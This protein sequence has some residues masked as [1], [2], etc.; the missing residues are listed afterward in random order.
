MKHAAVGGLAQSAARYACR[1]KRLNEHGH[2]G[3]ARVEIALSHGAPRVRRPQ[4][5]PT[6]PQCNQKFVLIA[7]TE[8]ALE[9]TGESG[10]EAIF[11]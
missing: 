6:R 7:D 4:G 3:I 11:D 1:D 9:L 8:E 5:G 2:R 10:V